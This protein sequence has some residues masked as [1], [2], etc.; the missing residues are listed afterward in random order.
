MRVIEWYGIIRDAYCDNDG[1]VQTDD[2]RWIPKFCPHDCDPVNLVTSTIQ[3]TQEEIDKRNRLT[4]KS[5]EMLTAMHISE[6]MRTTYDKGQQLYKESVDWYAQ[7]SAIMDKD[8]QDQ[9][10]QISIKV[11]TLTRRMA[12]RLT[13][14]TDQIYIS[15]RAPPRFK[16]CAMFQ[17]ERKVAKMAELLQKGKEEADQRNAIARQVLRK[18]TMEDTQFTLGNVAE[19]VRVFASGTVLKAEAKRPPSALDGVASGP[20]PKRVAVIKAPPAENPPENVKPGFPEDTM[21]KMITKAKFVG[22]ERGKDPV[23]KKPPGLLPPI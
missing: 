22:E 17:E 23:M 15:T 3:R 1:M 19:K 10:K 5:K 14:K 6:S 9:I 12:M 8:D 18:Q 7:K 2:G 16:S 13:N 21:A 20:P 4:Q 11:Q